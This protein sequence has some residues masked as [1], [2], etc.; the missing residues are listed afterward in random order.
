[1]IAF[2]VVILMPAKKVIYLK[3]QP[4][5]A[6]QYSGWLEE[7]SNQSSQIYGYIK[8]A[9]LK[10]PA[11]CPWRGP[12]HYKGQVLPTPTLGKEI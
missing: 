12:K 8:Q 6:M 7:Q 4:I 5:W 11:I 9:L 10:S 1:M 3:D 2:M